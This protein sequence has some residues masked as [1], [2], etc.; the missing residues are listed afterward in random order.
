VLSVNYLKK[1]MEEEFGIDVA[2]CSVG[3]VIGVHTGP[4]TVGAAVVFE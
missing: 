1:L 2:L 3:P 4:G